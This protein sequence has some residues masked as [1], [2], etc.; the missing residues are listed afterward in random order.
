MIRAVVWGATIVS[1][2]AVALFV[3]I[4]PAVLQ[5]AGLS[6]ATD[7]PVTDRP[8]GDRPSSQALGPEP[9]ARHGKP[10]ADRTRAIAAA[11]SESP[12]E[13]TPPATP[14]DP[15]TI[16]V[17]AD[18]ASDRGTSSLA[19]LSPAPTTLP[20]SAAPS[21]F[22][23]VSHPATSRGEGNIA[24]TRALQGELRRLGCYD[25]AIDGDW[26][27]ASRYAA[28][29]FTKAVN[30]ALPTDRPD[31]ILLALTRQHSGANCGSTDGQKLITAATID[32][33]DWAAVI[34]APATLRADPAAP[35]SRMVPAPRIVSVDGTNDPNPAGASIIHIRP[36]MSDAD[37][38]PRRMALGVEA[39]AASDPPAQPITRA[40]PDFRTGSAD[41][42]KRARRTQN[43]ERVEHNRSRAK[44]PRWKREVFQAI[45]LN[46]N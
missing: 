8:S 20:G 14:H 24:T 12:A 27:P 4:D 34:T 42:E 29:M 21:P 18:A 28:A 46:G 45:D 2:G 22:T 11:L 19:S 13:R 9:V 23:A 41:R 40:A 36:P 15:R 5:R 6:G 3:P 17:N 1:V 35:A 31:S 38:S 16:I 26:G 33:P 25:G 30:A 37:G 44:R 7:S 10:S 43:I 39:P 32:R